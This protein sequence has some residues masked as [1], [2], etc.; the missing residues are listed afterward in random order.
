MDQKTIDLI[1]SYSSSDQFIGNINS[2]PLGAESAISDAASGAAGQ[3][4][5]SPGVSAVA[6]GAI[7]AATVYF[8]HQVSK[9]EAKR[10][11]AV[12]ET[13]YWRQWRNTNRA[14]Y[15]AYDTQ[16][17]SWYREQD[18]VEAR[19]QYE[20]K[21]ADLQAGYKGE[22]TVAATK[23]FERQIADI[24]GR[25]YEEE[26]KDIIDLENTRI[27][28]ISQAVGKVASGQVGRSVEAFGQAKNQQWLANLSDRQLTRKFRIGDKEKAKVAADVAREN[29]GNQVRFYTPQP[30]ADPVNPTA[31]APLD[32]YQPTPEAAPASNLQLGI[33]LGKQALGAYDSYLG[34]L[35]QDKD[36]TANPAAT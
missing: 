5:W 29:T 7:K 25:F 16:L 21:R 36:I 31:P 33:S 9:H 13:K 12:A 26:A 15:R 10:K 32:F 11:S 24:E 34:M 19:R 4:F 6:T 14:N 3:S 27:S 1:S 28:L 18:W 8:D 20:Q 17:K 30:V 2:F 22:V 23:N 35:P